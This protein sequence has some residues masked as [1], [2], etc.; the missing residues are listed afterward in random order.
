[1]SKLAP[2]HVV[3]AA[4]PAQLTTELACA[5]TSLSES[6]FRLWAARYG[7]HPVEC[8]GLAV[9]R[10]RLAD[11]ARVIDSLPD[12]GAEMPAEPGH[13]QEPEDPAVAALARVK[14]RARG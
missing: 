5:Y 10:W 9:T 2:E 8:G 14:K 3:I 1:M 12:R 11:I 7:V 13:A 4:W 6:S